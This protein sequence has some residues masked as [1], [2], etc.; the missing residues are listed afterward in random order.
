[1]NPAPAVLAV[2]D[3]IEACLVHHDIDLATMIPGGPLMPLLQSLHLGRRIRCV[4]ARHES[5]AVMMAEG[6][7][8]VTGRPSVVALTAGPGVTNAVTGIALAK[9]EQ[10]AIVVLSAQVARSWFGK[11]AAQELEA[12][13]LLAPVTKCSLTLEDPADTWNTLSQAIA[14]SRAGCP[15]PVHLSVPADLWRAPCAAFGTTDDREPAAVADGPEPGQLRALSD[16]LARSRRPVVLVGYGVVLAR[17]EQ[18]LIALSRKYPQLRFSCTPR[19]KGAFPESHPR[20]VGVFG[21]AGHLEAERAIVEQSDLLLVLGS[22]LGEITTSGW[23]E[24]IGRRPIVQVDLDA[25][26]IGRNFPVQMGICADLGSVLAR[27][28]GGEPAATPQKATL[29][30]DPT[31]ARTRVE[32]AST[33]ETPAANAEAA[34]LIHPRHVVGVLN[35]A[36]EGDDA[37]W[38]DIGNGMAWLVHYLR[39]DQPRRWHVNLSWGSMGHALPGAVGGVLASGKPALVVVGDAAFAMTGVELHTAVEERLPLVVVVL[40]DS[41]HGMVELGSEFQFGPGQV[42]SARFRERIDASGFA[43]ALGADASTATTLRELEQALSRAWA[44]VAGTRVPHVIDVHVDPSAVPPFG[45]R[46]KLLKQNFSG[47]SRPQANHD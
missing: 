45:A 47:S 12:A 19:S 33:T 44:S 3:C 40:N 14:L 35:R 22:R 42:P 32:A 18:Q 38:C 27:L 39:R 26:V 28:I 1:M 11:G 5:G 25:S 24:R 9:A 10:S 41:G 34:A 17:A 37:V 15:G 30:P 16:A 6:Y 29:P 7:F 2:A 43:R 21:F 8:R 4:L 13:R 31:T 23:D 20:S 46:M 36:L